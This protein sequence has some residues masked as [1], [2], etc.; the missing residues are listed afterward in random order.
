MPTARND[1]GFRSG[2]SPTSIA[3]GASPV[4]ALGKMLM[5][6]DQDQDRFLLAVDQNS[7]KPVWKVERPEMVHSFWTPITHTMKSG[8]AEVIVPGSFQMTSNDVSNGELLWQVRGLTYQVKS[9]PL[10]AGDT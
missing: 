8:R 9:V 2:R 3:W 7:G 6:C 10:L 5:I 1:G 4:L